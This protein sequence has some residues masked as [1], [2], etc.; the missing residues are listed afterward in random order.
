MP[1]RVTLNDAK[2]Q[3]WFADLANPEVPLYK[4]G[5]SVPHGAKGHD[6]LDQLH[7]NNVAVERAVWL[8]RV[9]GANETVSK[10]LPS[11]ALSEQSQ[12]GLRNKPSYNPTQYSVEW[13]NIVTSYLR[14]QL[15]FIVLPTAPR[16][17]LTYKHTF[18]GVLSDAESRER[19]VSRFSYTY[20]ITL[21]IDQ[22]DVAQTVSSL[23]LLR[24]FYHEGL[25]DSKTFLSWLVQ[26]MKGCNLAQ[27]GFI[28]RIVNE[29]LDDIVK[30]L[31]LA[32]PVI[33]ASLNKLSE[34]RLKGFEMC[35]CSCSSCSRSLQTRQMTLLWIPMH[36]SELIYTTFSP[37]YPMRLSAPVFGRSMK[38]SSK[39]PSQ[40]ASYRKVL[41]K[42]NLGHAQ[43]KGFR[44]DWSIFADAMTAWP[45]ENLPQK[46]P[47][48]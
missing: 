9:F 36:S 31:A 37:L 30:S 21:R 46:Y 27:G 28:T 5:K 32:K 26:Q 4:L 25:V 19:W 45:L 39:A 8:L 40:K 43:E 47:Q 16:P 10:P 33:E 24:T 2:R 13:A 22:A 14:K 20:V 17:G 48:S 41:L 3:A 42:A 12:A 1:P 44:K 11:V 18:K 29:Y 15:D 34:V 35:I 7:D 23:K 6:L 38:L